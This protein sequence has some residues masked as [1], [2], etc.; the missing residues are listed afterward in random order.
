MKVEPFLIGSSLNLVVAQRLVRRI[1]HYCR[2]PL[3]LPENVLEEIRAILDTLSENS[4]PKEIR[5]KKELTFYFGEKCSRCEQ[6]GYK[7]RVAIAEVLEITD[8]LKQMIIDGTIQNQEKM[9]EE[10]KTQGMASM[11]ADGILKALAGLTTIEEVFS[12]TKE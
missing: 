4:I 6:T 11:K 10:T 12:L 7:G 9:K 1:C 2:K 3:K 8:N 5:E